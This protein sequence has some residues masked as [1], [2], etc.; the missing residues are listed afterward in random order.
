[1]GNIAIFFGCSDLSEILIQWFYT[2]PSF[3]DLS[4]YWKLLGSAL[5]SHY[6]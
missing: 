6:C 5:K 2:D 3:N 4:S 1:M